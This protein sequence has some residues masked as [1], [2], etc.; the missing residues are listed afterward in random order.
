MKTRK[1]HKGRAALE[2]E[3]TS[4]ER[5]L[6]ATL[7]ERMERIR[8]GSSNRSGEFMDTVSNSELDEMTARIVESDSTKVDEIEAALQR[9][10]EDKYGICSH[11][12]GD[13]TKKRLKARPFAT[14]C[15]DCK[16]EAEKS[17]SGRRER[18]DFRAPFSIS[19]DV[20]TGD[21]AASESER[22]DTVRGN[23]F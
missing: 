17:D 11:C 15:V 10:R 6:L 16:Q 13:I 2:K 22:Y 14:L 18:G 7:R 5:N 8:A 9:L 20:G 19:A 23:R 3:L 21:E 4:L 12:G 1:K